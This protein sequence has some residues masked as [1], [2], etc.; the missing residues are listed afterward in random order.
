MRED[1]NVLTAIVPR[2]DATLTA[3]LTEVRAMHAQHNRLSSRV[4]A[5]EESNAAHSQL[6]ASSGG[7]KGHDAMNIHAC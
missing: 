2:Q 6:P 1:L 7:W 3:L 5:L 4:R